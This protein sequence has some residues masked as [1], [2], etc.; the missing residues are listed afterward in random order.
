[1]RI[2]NPIGDEGEARAIGY[3]NLL[4]YSVFNQTDLIISVS[5]QP[6]K[7]LPVGIQTFKEIIDADF[8][9]V[10]KTKQLY[11]L[12]SGGK[13]YFLSRPRRFGKSLTLS[14]IKEIFEGN[15]AL[16]KGLW[17]EKNWDWG[18]TNPVLHLHFDAMGYKDKG[19][20]GAMETFLKAE[21][22]KHDIFLQ[23]EGAG[24]LFRELLIKLNEKYSRKVVVLIDEY[25]KPI[26][27]FIEE[28]DKAK[29]QQEVLKSFYAVI[30]SS[31]QYIRFLLITGVSKFSKVSVFSDL[32][33][34][35]DITIDRRFSTLV[36]Y[37]QEELE[38]YFEPHLTVIQKEENISKAVLLK[39]IKHWYNGYT[40]DV[41]HYV[42]NPFS[43]LSFFNKRTF[44]NFWFSTGTPTFLI[45]LLK[46]QVFYDLENVE[47]D[48]SVFE[49]YS[50]DNMDLSALL[51]QTGYLTIK[52]VDEYGVYTL[53]YPNQEVKESMLRHLIG[54]FR[55]ESKSVN[56]PFVVKLRHA[57]FANDTATAISIIN[58]TFKSIPSHLFLAKKEAYYHSLIH[59]VFTLLG[60]FLE[61]EVHTSDGRVDAVL[62]TDKHIYILEFKLD[63]SAALALKQIKEKKYADRFLNQGK[64]VIGLGINFSSENKAVDGWLEEKLYESQQ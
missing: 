60:Q 64:T 51:F 25:D 30:K 61:S 23:E 6:M 49:S 41:K 44:H 62:K 47:V 22:K 37:T 54:A 24:S 18:H 36:G 13:Y 11:Q 3:Y 34:L 19:L 38:K 52:K 56:T 14:T 8:L 15:K 48:S 46:E 27:D 39:Q 5:L 28:V 2:G 43:V 17:I 53:S 10:D 12:I 21:G 57:F 33:N 16:F 4:I 42:Y 20:K 29:A 31:D 1:M 7:K 58:S 26:I 40:W 59:L 35:E 55:H 50:L 32:N 63:K 45:K 9:Y